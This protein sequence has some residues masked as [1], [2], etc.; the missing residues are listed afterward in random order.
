VSKS[1]RKQ[2]RWSLYASDVIPT[3]RMRKFMV[4]FRYRRGTNAV[5]GIKQ[6][7]GVVM[8]DE[9]VLGCCDAHLIQRKRLGNDFQQKLEK[10]S[11][12]TYGMALVGFGEHGHLRGHHCHNPD[13]KGSGV[14]QEEPNSADMLLFEELIIDP[15]WRRQGLSTRLVESIVEQCRL[16]SRVFYG[17]RFATGLTAEL[18]RRISEVDKWN[19]DRI[20]K[21]LF[22][23]DV[24]SELTFTAANFWRGL[25]FRRIGLSK[26]FAFAN[27]AHHPSHSIAIDEN[28]SIECADAYTQLSAHGEGAP[29]ALAPHVYISVPQTLHP[30]FYSIITFHRSAGLEPNTIPTC[31]QATDRHTLS[32]MAMVTHTTLSQACKSSNTAPTNATSSSITCARISSRF[33]LFAERCR[34]KRITA[35]D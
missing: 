17:I 18:H 30:S 10:Y 24:S 22:V 29:L 12:G 33:Q 31:R 21:E 8:I 27:D 6:I 1:N 19:E 20:W 35:T 26:Y 9:K 2:K 34:A 3:A 11:D 25:D 4:T 13:K 15:P 14:G 7:D 23:E 32:P 28:L 16:E 5:A